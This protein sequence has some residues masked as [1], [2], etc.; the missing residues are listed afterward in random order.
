MKGDGEFLTTKVANKDGNFNCGMLASG[1]GREPDDSSLLNGRRLTEPRS[2]RWA[3]R[4]RAA[5]SA[6]TIGTG[7]R[8]I[9]LNE[10]DCG[11]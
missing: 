4:S 9:H 3:A 2:G 8:L 5:G 1:G 7:P 11:G 6:V 10:G